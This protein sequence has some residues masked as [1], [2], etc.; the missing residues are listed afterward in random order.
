MKSVLY[1][2][3]LVSLCWTQDLAPGCYDEDSNLITTIEMPEFY[4]EE[5][6]FDCVCHE[7]CSACGYY[8]YPT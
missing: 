5:E 7:S 3:S 6:P 8:E 4:G 2:L 1:L